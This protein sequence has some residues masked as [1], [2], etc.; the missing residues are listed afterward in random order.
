ME[1]AVRN[2]IGWFEIYVDD[3]A[4]ARAF[5]EAML[6]CQ[7]QEL[8]NAPGPEAML[9][10]P[11]GGPGAPGATGSLV[12]MEGVKAGGNSTLVYFSCEDCAVQAARAA[13]HGGR[14]SKEKFSIGEYGFIALVIDTEG[15][16]IGLYSQQ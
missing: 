13:Q 7:L 15:N 1:Q 6:E 4:R 10:F 9:V 3:M 2:P 8:P 11:S 16:M 14:I 5:Y 12:Q